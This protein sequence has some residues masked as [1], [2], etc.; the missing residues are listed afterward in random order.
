MTSEERDKVESYNAGYH[1][2]LHTEYHRV[3]INWLFIN[4]TVAARTVLKHDFDE[5]KKGYV[6]GVL[7][8]KESMDVRE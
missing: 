8:Y 1:R 6:Q 7:D 3:P 4:W 2:G 5:F